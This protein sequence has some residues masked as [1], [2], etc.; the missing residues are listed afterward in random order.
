MLLLYIHAHADINECETGTDSCDVS[1]ECTN[2]DGSYTCSCTSGY[3]GD[4]FTCTS[5]IGN[6]HHMSMLISTHML[7]SR[8]Q[9]MY[10]GCLFREC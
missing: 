4:G 2:T 7:I 5:T 6:Q 9:F 3:S 10:Y 8:Y 1:A